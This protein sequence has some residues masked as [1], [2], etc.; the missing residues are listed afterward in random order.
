MADAARRRREE[1]GR[2]MDRTAPPHR[3]RPCKGISLTL[4][5][6]LFHLLLGIGDGEGEDKRHDNQQHRDDVERVCI[7]HPGDEESR[8]DG[9]RRFAD[10]PDRAKDA[11]GRPHAARL[12]E[13]R[14]KGRGDGVTEATP[15]PR[16]A[17]EIIRN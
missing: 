10:I 15:S 13:I 3:S 16:R 12:D 17:E 4:L 5:S 14:H 7:A 11:H 2:E 8:D 1:A 6:R 9:P